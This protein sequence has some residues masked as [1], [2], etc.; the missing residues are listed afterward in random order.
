MS[1]VNKNNKI[2]NTV[3]FSFIS[4]FMALVFLYNHQTTLTPPKIFVTTE[5]T[6]FKKVS[7]KTHFAHRVY[8]R[9]GIK[10][11]FKLYSTS[12]Y[13]N[14]EKTS[15]TIEFYSKNLIG[16]FSSIQTKTTTRFDVI[17]YEKDNQ[18]GSGFKNDPFVV[19]NSSGLTISAI[20]NKKEDFVRCLVVEN[21]FPVSVDDFWFGTDFFAKVTSNDP[22]KNVELFVQGS[23]YGKLFVHC[24]T[25][26]S[27]DSIVWETVVLKSSLIYRTKPDSIVCSFD[28]L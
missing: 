1:N 4:L 6:P 5:N 10:E 7:F 15:V 28:A 2:T 8:Y 23:F 26:F 27:E 3:V 14:T 25:A 24:A 17:K 11:A 21:P 18:K 13:V 9:K 20:K 22:T 19:C 12:Y 16:I